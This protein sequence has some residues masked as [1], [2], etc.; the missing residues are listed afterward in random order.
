MRFPSGEAVPVLGMGTW[1][2]GS[3]PGRRQDEIVA[4]RTGLDL[5]MTL[6]DTAEMYGSGAAE[7]LVGEA[8]AGRRDEVFLVTKVLPSH[9]RRA[10]TVAACE[11]SLQRLATDRIDLY[12]LH[13]P[14]PTPLAETVGAFDDLLGAGKIR[15]WGVSNFDVAGME[16]VL[17]V[18]GGGAVASDQVL[19]NLGRR[20]I[21]PALLGFCQ[22][23]DIPV[24]AYT[25]LGQGDLL[26]HPALR[27][28]ARTREATP[29]QVALAWT[30][31][32]DGIVAIPKAGSANHVRE[33]QG[34]L[35]LELTAEDLA[36]LD[37]AFPPPTGD[38]RLDTA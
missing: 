7:T 37:D 21:E 33:N 30:L 25:P 4:L 29:A 5:G 27:S 28:V 3:N 22:A 13:W 1:Q 6:I 38:P 16:E 32:H 11:S 17:G 20:S 23:R 24:M 19:Y 8:I 14:A 10:D 36:A 35:G 31:R 18:P 34:A 12:L 9:A 26:T 2:M 15:S